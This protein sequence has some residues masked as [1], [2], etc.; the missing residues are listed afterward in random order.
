MER[1][2]LANG[3]IGVCIAYVAWRE[4]RAGNSRDSKFL[5]V[6]AA[7]ALTATLGTA[8]YVRLYGW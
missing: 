5:Q 3:I 7:V 1:L 8:F 2:L 4:H 6:A